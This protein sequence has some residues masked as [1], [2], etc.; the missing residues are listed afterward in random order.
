MD[1]VS[2]GL[3]DR[4]SGSIT[5]AL[6]VTAHDAIPAAPKFWYFSI[7]NWGRCL[8]WDFCSKSGC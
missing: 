2:Y 5:T 7:S 4:C 8:C 1:F 3:N 6:F